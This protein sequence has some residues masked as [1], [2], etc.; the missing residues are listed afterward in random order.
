M[1]KPVKF[2]KEGVRHKCVEQQ[3]HIE[4]DNDRRRRPAENFQPESVRELSHLRLFTCEP[5]QRPD[6]EA[7]LHRQDN[8]TGDQQLRGFAFAKNGNNKHGWN[9]RQ[10]AGD[11]SAKP[12]P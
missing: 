11:Q 8:L 5:H 10:R 3:F 4:H 1:Q 7:E 9:D 2:L 12:R 6:G